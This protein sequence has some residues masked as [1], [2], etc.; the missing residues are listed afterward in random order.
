MPLDSTMSLRLSQIVDGAAPTI[1]AQPVDGYTAPHARIVNTAVAG[2]HG[3]VPVRVYSTLAADEFG[4][5][6]ATAI[7]WVHGGGF[8][9]GD[10]DMPEADT[11][12]RELVHRLGCVV[13]SVD[14]RLALGGVQFPVPLDDVVAVTEAALAGSLVP[15]ASAFTSI[16]TSVV[17]GGASAGA[18]LALAAALRLKHRDTTLDDRTLDAL[19]LVYPYLHAINPPPAQALTERM[20]DIAAGARFSADSLRAMVV[21]YLGTRA[22]EPPALAFPGDDADLGGLPQ[23]LI[24]G[25]EYDDLLSSAERGAAGLTAAGVLVQQYLEPG[26]L[27]GHLNTPGLPG[28]L[29]TLE[30]MARFI[31]LLEKKALQQ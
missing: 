25:A 21:N 1:M 31:C 17:L 23:T 12:A 7:V 24:V 20:A 11:V 3:D 6:A 27:H 10:L 5:G 16:C 2:P 19:L 4:A 18:N 28:A 8:L 29:R 22:D 30:A 26:V 13:Y 15:P 14:Y 9:A